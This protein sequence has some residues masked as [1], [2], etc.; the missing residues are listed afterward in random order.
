[1]NLRIRKAKANDI[2]HLCSL[3]AILL[4]QEAEFKPDRELQERGFKL[5]LANPEKGFA[6]ITELDGEAVAMCTVLMTI[7]T[8]LGGPAAVLEDVVVRPE[9][10]GK[11]IGSA[12][13]NEVK[14]MIEEAGCLR[15]SLLT[16]NDNARGQKF[17]SSHGFTSSPMIP[18]RL[19]L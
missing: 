1:M 9:H 17:Y 18:M 19:I 3:L 14:R 10:R 2:S 8:A 16:D 6:V 4:D 12:M 7:S 13:I 15:I 5:L 11:G